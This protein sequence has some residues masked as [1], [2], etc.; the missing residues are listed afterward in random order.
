LK[1][2]FIFGEAGLQLF[3]SK[4]KATAHCT[5]YLGIYFLAISSNTE[6]DDDI[7]EGVIVHRGVMMQ[8][9]DNENHIGIADEIESYPCRY[10]AD[11][12][13]LTPFG[14]EKHT[15]ALHCEHLDKVFKQITKI[16][17]EWR[18]LVKS[19]LKDVFGRKTGLLYPN[20]RRTYDPCRICGILI[21]ILHPSAMINHMRAH[22]KNDELRNQL[23][24]EYGVEY[25]ERVTCNECQLVF[26]DD[27][28]L[29]AHTEFTHARKRKYICKWCGHLCQSMGLLNA[30]KADVHGMPSTRFRERMR[31][32][33]RRKAVGET[34]GSSF[35]SFRTACEFC[36]LIMV[37]PSL[38]IRHMLR[39]HN[40]SIF[41]AVI[42]MKKTPPVKV[43]VD[44]GRLTWLCCE[45]SYYDR[46]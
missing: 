42:E 26:S 25:V 16:H 10:C 37:K 24:A 41:T 23:L 5:I 2:R 39:V 1:D 3:R 36:D 13:F 21:N 43:E 44:N 32:L 29:L 6:I 30:H 20:I 35:F 15:K 46:H 11:R 27:N 19:S 33:N 9:I 28:K 22:T 14:L 8:L 4:I 38:L 12:V 45:S 31:K 40:R 18:R 7:G 17:N 34:A